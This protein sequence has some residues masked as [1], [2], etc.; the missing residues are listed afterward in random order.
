MRSIMLGAAAVALLATPGLANA[1]TNAVVGLDFNSVDFGSGPGTWDVYGLNGAFNHD[2]SNG[3][4]VQLDGYAGR[5]SPPHFCCINTDYAALHFGMRHDSYSMAGFVGLMSAEPFSGIDVGVEGQMQF[6]QAMLEGSLSY[7]D[8]GD[9]DLNATNVQ[10]DGSWFVNPDFAVNALVGYTDA[11]EGSSNGHW[12]SYGLSG[13]YRFANS[14]A[15]VSLGYRRF[16]ESGAHVDTWSI[17]LT[18]DLG[19]GTLQDRSKSGPSW[20]GGRSLYDNVGRTIGLVF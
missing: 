4:E 10:V 8:F 7:V 11:N 14:P 5:A 3:W 2:F 6:T 17:G 20:N 15:S 1:Q 12:W 9:I 19:T 16:D 18:L 13:E